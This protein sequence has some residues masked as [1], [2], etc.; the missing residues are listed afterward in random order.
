MFKKYTP[1][2][3]EEFAR[4]RWVMSKNDVAMI[5]A[6]VVLFVCSLILVIGT[7]DA[8]MSWLWPAAMAESTT[9]L[10]G[11]LKVVPFAAGLT[12]ILSLLLFK[13]DRGQRWLQSR[14]LPADEEIQDRLQTAMVARVRKILARVRCAGCGYLQDPEDCRVTCTCADLEVKVRLG[15]CGPVNFCRT[16]FEGLRRADGTLP[17]EWS[18]MMAELEASMVPER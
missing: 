8:V 4:P 10:L 11:L 16:C 2:E 14:E 6:T 1:E 3:K 12:V 13:R 15:G 17:P 5:G 7:I 9:G 18:D